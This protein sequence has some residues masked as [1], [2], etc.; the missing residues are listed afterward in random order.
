MNATKGYFSLV[1]YCPDLARQ[2]AANVGVVLF[3]PERKFIRAKTADTI[4]RIRR[5]FGQDA[6]GYHHLHGMMD[7]L[8]HRLVI[9]QENFKTLEDLQQFIDTRANKI[10][11]TS[12]KPML[13]TEPQADL[14]ALYLELVAEPTK[15][16]TIQAEIP[17]RKRLD[18]VLAEDE[19]RRFIQRK[20]EV[21][22]ST[23]RETLRV[24][25]GFQNGRF[26][27]IRPVEFKH[28]NESGVKAAACKH[29]VEG[30]SLHRHRDA[31][32]G[33]LQLI[34]VGDFTAA[35]KDS[36]EMVA[37]I[38]REHEVRLVMPDELSALKQE[39]VAHA[40]LAPAE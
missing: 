37:G 9:E 25:Y 26:N 6:D 2:E 29:A 18:A 3:C 36:T 30:L 20:I 21:Q 27:L 10:I 34:V 39:I 16:L 28:Q 11:L 40:R 19:V 14:Q 31:K 33:E 15:P 24:P 7:A 8:S 5:F 4:G 32:Y 1:Q 22:V 13:V 38:F 17:L 12:P 23:L 35:P